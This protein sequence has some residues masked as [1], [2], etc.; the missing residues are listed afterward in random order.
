MK[1]LKLRAK[2]TSVD[3]LNYSTCYLNINF[4][5]KIHATY[6]TQLEAV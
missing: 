5:T 2:Y 6:F 3:Y 1:L 4:D